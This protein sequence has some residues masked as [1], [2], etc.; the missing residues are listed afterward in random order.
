MLV[1]RSGR[2]RFASAEMAQRHV[3][4]DKLVGVVLNEVKPLMLNTYYNRSYYYYGNKNGYPY[5]SG[6]K[7]D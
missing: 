4:P 2:T 6:Q 3:N 5:H 7:E 1:V